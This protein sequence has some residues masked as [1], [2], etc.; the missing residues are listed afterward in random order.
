[1]VLG[2]FTDDFYR[3]SCPAC[4]LEATVAI[5]DYGRYSAVRDWDLGDVDRRALRPAQAAD[6]VGPGLWMHEL[7][8]RDGQPKLAEGLTFLFGQAECPRCA[9]IFRVSEAHSPEIPST[10]RLT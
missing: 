4:S 8:V 3:V 6:L 5:G 2:D 10:E 9:S 1:M 7:A